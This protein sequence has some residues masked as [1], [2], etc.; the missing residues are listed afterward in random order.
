MNRAAAVPAL[1]FLAIGLPACGTPGSAQ[2]CGCDTTSG[3]SGPSD[4]GGFSTCPAGMI[5]NSGELSDAGVSSGFCVN[6][7]YSVSGSDPIVVDHVTGLTWPLNI[8]P[9]ALAWNADAGTG[10]AQAYC[11]SLNLAGTGWRLPTLPELYSLVETGDSTFID[12]SAFPGAPGS[13]TWTATPGAQGGV[14][15]V[16]FSAGETA[17]VDAGI[18]SGENVRCVR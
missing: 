12:T 6:P 16:D 4:A 11:G 17:A 10:S 1:M 18:A 8:A 5:C 7:D 9:M 3:C 13:G 14:W 15:I 2:P